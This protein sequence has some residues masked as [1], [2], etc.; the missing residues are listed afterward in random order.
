MRTRLLFVRF[1]A[2]I[3]AISI[4]TSRSYSQSITTNNNKWEIGL[5][6]GPMF[7]LGDLGG[8]A[9]IGKPFILD[10]DM[11]MTK[12][13]KNIYVN[14]YVKEWL[15]FRV[16]L[17][18]GVLEG[19]D[20]QAP[21]KGGAEM[22]RLE[23]NLSFR[24]NI[25][26]AYAAAEFY[27]TVFLEKFDGLMGKLRPYGIVGFG[28]FKFNPKAKLDGQ[29]I[30]LHPLRLEGEGMAEY[31]DRKPYSLTQREI[32]MGFG[33][34]YYLKENFYIGMEVLHRKL[35]TDYVDDV[36]KK[37]IDP[38]YFSNYLSPADAANARRL[39]YR[40]TYQGAPGAVQRPQD[41]LNYQRGDP[42]L[43]DA[44][45]STIIRFGWRLGGENSRELKHLRCPTF[46]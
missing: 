46:F 4:F 26:E 24:T 21:S 3:F 2:L 40:G 34:K 35:F 32:P 18:H 27:P 15:G 41:V 6:L 42:T 9:G 7:F 13:S 28:M 37:Y 5:G 45:F 44:Y 31:P 22:D 29:W 39:Y 30:A 17:N 10:L 23:R 11:P 16:A 25:F 36:S 14:Y 12:I 8:S 43:N 38:V 20:A 19:D 33:F 1:I